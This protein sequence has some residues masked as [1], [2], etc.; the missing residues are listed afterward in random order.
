M[1][2]EKIPTLVSRKSKKEDTVVQLGSRVFGGADFVIVAG[3]CAVESE[4]QLRTIAGSVARAGADALRGGAY[5]PRTSPYSF[6]GLKDEGLRYLAMM[7]E[8][9][10]LPVVTEVV[11]VAAVESVAQV[12][13]VLQIG[14][15]NMHHVA[16][17]HA[18]AATKKPIVLKRGPGSTVIEWLFAAEYILAA[19]NPNVILCERGIRTFETMTRYTLDLGVL[20]ILREETHLPIFVDPSHGTG[21]SIAVGPLAKAAAA[22]GAHGV[23]I[24]V[25]SDPKA[26]L[27]DGEQALTCETFQALVPALRAVRLASG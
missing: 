14:A 19:G 4:H 15:R 27:C 22:L 3:P 24:E 13:D 6:Q 23:M 17:L 10:G 11:D 20:P 16:L 2:D 21:R 7:R 5:K 26:A 25:H 1:A 18:A 8:E 12:A 9:T